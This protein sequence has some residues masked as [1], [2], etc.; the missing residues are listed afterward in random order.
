MK[1][2]IL[3]GGEGT[4]LGLLTKSIPKPLIPIAGPPCIDYVIKSL[5]SASFKQIIITTGYMSDKLLAHI[6]DGKQFGASIQF[7]FEESPAGTAGAVRN[8]KN[9]LNNTFVVASGDVLAEVDIGSIYHFHKSKGAIATMALT[10]VEN[11]T[12]FG[13]VGIDEENRIV[14]FKEKPKEK[15]IFSNLIN[16]GI[17]VLEPTV[18]EFIPDQ[19]MFDF[20]KDLFPL[21]LKKGLP[22]YGKPI[23]G[24]WM[25]IGRLSDVLNASFAIIERNGR[26]IEIEDVLSSG[27]M[28][29]GDNNKFGKSVKLRGP[30]YIGDHVKFGDDA[31]V[32]RSCVYNYVEIESGTSIKNSVIFQGCKLGRDNEITG[33]I[34]SPNCHLE[35]Q[36]EIL[37]SIIGGGKKVPAGSKIYNEGLPKR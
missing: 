22:L 32:E 24:L 37:N 11:P 15:E 20:S 4:R 19:G 18:L 21:I 16:A 6:G 31:H 33:S 10:S 8:I 27:S 25:D 2:V 9:H 1:A 36:V 7:A 28:V 14:K 13:I 3:A 26:E 29:M 23:Q 35:G 17:Y 30:S 12:E 34:L 5:T